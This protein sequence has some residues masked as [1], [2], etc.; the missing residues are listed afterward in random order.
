MAWI[1]S[2]QTLAGHPK[3][4]KLAHLLGV[5]RPTAIGHLHCFWWWALDYADDGDLSRHDDLDIAI[6]A[7]W[8]GDSGAF[9]DAI[10]AVGFIEVNTDGMRTIHDWY[11][12]A[13]KLVD[14]KKANAE[15]MR[16]AREAEKEERA[17]H[18]QGTQRTRVGL[19][20][21]TV[22][23]QTKPNS[24]NEESQEFKTF[25]DNAYPRKKARA[26]AWKAW[27]SVNPNAE[28][29]EKIISAARKQAETTYKG[30]ESKFIPYP[31][32]WLRA[33]Q[34]DDAIEGPRSPGSLTD[35]KGGQYG[36]PREIERPDLIG[37]ERM[38]WLKERHEQQQRDE[39]EAEARRASS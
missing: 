38:R 4:R 27:C 26:D 30:M 11:D 29:A 31:A 5:S 7:D 13:G 10:T 23:N 20:N 33:G 14:R 36:Q 35:H 22:P 12:Y 24:A 39:Q 18:V 19:P 16:L 37:P 15:R 34:W 17:A 28:L 1:E 32:T 21:R 3:T 6:G 25:Y 8:E 2:H 9:V